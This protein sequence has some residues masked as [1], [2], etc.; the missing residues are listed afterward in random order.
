MT[1][2]AQPE[3]E[4]NPQQQRAAEEPP[5]NGGSRGNPTGGPSEGGYAETDERLYRYSGDDPGQPSVSASGAGSG[6]TSDAEARDLQEPVQR[7]PDSDPAPGATDQTV[8][9]DQSAPATEHGGVGDQAPL[10]ADQR[11]R[12]DQA[13]PAIEQRAAPDSQGELAPG[14]VP[15][16]P[17]AALWGTEEI[18][19]FRDQWRQLQMRFVDDPHNAANEA[20]TLVDQAVHTLTTALGSRKQELDSWRASEGDDT[21]VLRMALRRYRDFLDRLL[22]A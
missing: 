15:H 5:A 10:A 7:R 16:D 9:T 20:A 13:E 1:Y 18:D 17:V 3:A 4:Q 22:G 8:T 12:P 14:D 6:P 19:R 2:P 11:G 21:E